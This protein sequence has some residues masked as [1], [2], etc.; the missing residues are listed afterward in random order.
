MW[1]I[2]GEVI[3]PDANTPNNSHHSPGIEH[4]TQIEI[5]HSKYG[6][7][8]FSTSV[9]DDDTVL[10]STPDHHGDDFKSDDS[11]S[12]GRKLSASHLRVC[13]QL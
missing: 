11:L 12:D 2:T 6:P 3:L 1:V 7:H 9:D 4:M 5:K 8:R 13:G 10:P